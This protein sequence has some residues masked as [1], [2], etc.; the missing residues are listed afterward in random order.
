LGHSV[1]TQLAFIMNFKR[2]VNTM[3]INCRSN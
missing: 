1:Y 3:N 2:N